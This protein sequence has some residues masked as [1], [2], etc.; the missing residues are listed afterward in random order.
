M[1]GY[2]DDIALLAAAKTPEQAHMAISDMVTWPGGALDWLTQHN[3]M[4]EAS[5]SVLIDFS[6]SRTITRPPMLLRG[7]VLTPQPAYKFL[8]VMLDQELRWNQQASY[9]VAK[10]SK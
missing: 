5:K 9:A 8:G 1:L 7:I 2:V 4:F 6:C 3:S 10:A